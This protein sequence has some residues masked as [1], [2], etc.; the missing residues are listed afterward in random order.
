LGDRAFYVVNGDF[1][2]A[3]LKGHQAQEVQGVG[4]IWIDCQNLPVDLLGSLT[5]SGLMMLDG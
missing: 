5:P 3:H 2:L 4:M 1:V